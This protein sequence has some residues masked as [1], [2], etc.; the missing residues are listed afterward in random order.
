MRNIDW[1]V[2]GAIVTNYLW[3]GA[4]AITIWKKPIKKIIKEYYEKIR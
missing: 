1:F 3:L 4:L 2:L